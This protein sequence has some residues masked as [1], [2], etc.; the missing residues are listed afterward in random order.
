MR[1]GRRADRLKA[2]D[3]FL[4]CPLAVCPGRLPALLGWKWI[5][6]YPAYQDET[7]EKTPGVQAC[8]MH[9][10]SCNNSSHASISPA[11]ARRQ[12]CCAVLCCTALCCDV[13]APASASPVFQRGGPLGR[14]SCFSRHTTS[15]PDQTPFPFLS[16]CLAAWVS[17]LIDRAGKCESPLPA[18]E[19]IQQWQ[20]V[21]EKACQSGPAVPQLPPSSW[22]CL[23]RP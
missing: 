20:A 19:L 3:P 21:G 17:S 1:M 7:S 13:A 12:M 2:D 10:P 18:D 23:M 14:R 9:T 15:F 11:I 16:L 8:H 22:P 4:S 5:P 6:P